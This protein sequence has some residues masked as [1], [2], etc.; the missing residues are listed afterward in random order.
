MGGLGINGERDW[1]KW[2]VMGMNG[3]DEWGMTGD[4]SG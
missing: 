3:V 4:E 1:F 2:G